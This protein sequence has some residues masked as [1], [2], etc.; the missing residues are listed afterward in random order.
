MKH[1]ELWKVFLS[2][3]GQVLDVVQQAREESEE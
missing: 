3:L 1:Y 2:C